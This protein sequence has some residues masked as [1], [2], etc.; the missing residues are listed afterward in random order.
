VSQNVRKARC[1][2]HSVTARRE[3][4]VIP[5]SPGCSLHLVQNLTVWDWDWVQ[6]IEHQ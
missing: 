3:D 4:G 1:P 6:R 5:D 2:C